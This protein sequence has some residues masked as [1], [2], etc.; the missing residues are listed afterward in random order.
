MFTIIQGKPLGGATHVMASLA[1]AEEKPVYSN[2]PLMYEHKS[3]NF[4]EIDKIQ[5]SVIALSNPMEILTTAP[6]INE[7]KKNLLIALLQS[8]SLNNTIYATISGQFPID[9]RCYTFCDYF[10]YCFPAK[11]GII[12]FTLR[13]TKQEHVEYF[14]LNV[15]NSGGLLSY[16]PI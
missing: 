9:S 11:R 12:R 8:N 4:N 7:N 2:S 6:E 5:N 13:K 3:V 14:N 15:L 1:K 10:I 16:F